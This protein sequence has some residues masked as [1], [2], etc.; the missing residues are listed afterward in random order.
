MGDVTSL[1][2]AANQG[3]ALANEDLYNL[4]YRQLRSI[5]R[6]K[7]AAESVDNTLQPTALVNEAFLAL[8]MGQTV[9]SNDRAHF[10][11]TAARAMERIL[12]DYARRRNCRK[13]SGNA[14]RIPMTPAI[15][16]TPA[17]DPSLLDLQ[18]ALDKL[19]VLAPQNS[20]LVRLHFFGG[21]TIKEC[22]SVMQISV[23]TAERKWRF[24]RAWL[25]DHIGS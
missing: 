9:I 18:A 23:S 8:A 22:A 4:V 20:E 6:R 12:I 19:S 17:V 24:A 5:A 21:L 3:D 25:R 11:R 14:K 10:F 1:I 7:M 16:Q 2:K 13:R 15:V